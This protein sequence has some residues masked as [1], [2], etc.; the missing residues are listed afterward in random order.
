MKLFLFALFLFPTLAQATGDEFLIDGQVT[1]LSAIP[2]PLVWWM[3]G[4]GFSWLYRFGYCDASP[5]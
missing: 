2:E 1:T 4:A 5:T 3:F